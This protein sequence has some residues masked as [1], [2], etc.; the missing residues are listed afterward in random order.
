MK[1]VNEMSGWKVR[2]DERDVQMERTHEWKVRPNEGDVR[3]EGTP[4][5]KYASMLGKEDERH[6]G[7]VKINPTKICLNKIAP[8][9]G[10]VIQ[11]TKAK[12]DGSRF[13]FNFCKNFVPFGMIPASFGI[14]PFGTEGHVY[15]SSTCFL[16]NL[17]FR[18]CAKGHVYVARL[19]FFGIVKRGSCMQSFGMVPSV[20]FPSELCWVLHWALACN[21]SERFLQYH[22]LRNYVGHWALYP[23]FRNKPFVEVRDRDHC[24]TCRVT[25]RYGT[26]HL[27]LRHGAL[28]SFTIFRVMVRYDFLR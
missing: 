26:L 7:A 14:I 6:V 10:P 9:V 27:S 22:S 8:S 16:R 21:R 2:P 3:M 20:S 11:S 5:W 23:P 4:E 28:F 17:A 1:G 12:N 24:I 15:D 18:H 25:L 13:L 19:V